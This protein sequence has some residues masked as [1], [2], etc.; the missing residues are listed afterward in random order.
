[1]DQSSY[2]P[3]TDYE[4]ELDEDDL[5]TRPCSRCLKCCE[6]HQD[7][8]C[9]SGSD[10]DDSAKTLVLDAEFSSQCSDCGQIVKDESKVVGP[11]QKQP[12]K[13]GRCIDCACIIDSIESFQSCYDC[14]MRKR[15]EVLKSMSSS[16]TCSSDEGDEPDSSSS[17]ENT[18]EADDLVS[19]ESDREEEKTVMDCD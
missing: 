11:D 7:D 10:S 19:S 8:E 6:R 18:D 17:S 2:C 15:T 1:M 14:S 3:L 13:I 4:S 5:L 12:E 9:H 16:L